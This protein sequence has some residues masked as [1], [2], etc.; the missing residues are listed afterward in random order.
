MPLPCH[1]PPRRRTV[2]SLVPG[3]L[4]AS[5]PHF[6]SLASGL[7]ICLSH[8]HT[9]FCCFECFSLRRAQGGVL[10]SWRGLLECSLPREAFPLDFVHDGISRALRRLPW[11]GLP[12]LLALWTTLCHRRCL[13]TACAS[14]LHL[15]PSGHRRDSTVQSESGL[16]EASCVDLKEG[17]TR[18]RSPSCEALSHRTCHLSLTAAP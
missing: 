11:P 3:C 5:C 10:S 15:C 7:G 1:F 6:P 4:P 16:E 13:L 2:P 14:G 9:R 17:T 8:L 12:F 18:P